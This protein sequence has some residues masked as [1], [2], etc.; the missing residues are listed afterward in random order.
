MSISSNASSP[1]N[2]ER[3]RKA[4][5]QDT[6]SAVKKKKPTEPMSNTEEIHT[7]NMAHQ[8]Q[9]K[10]AFEFGRGFGSG[11]AKTPENAEIGF[12][13][14]L[15]H[16]SQK[17]DSMG[18]TKATQNDTQELAD[19]VVRMPE[20]IQ[21]QSNETH[22]PA[23]PLG[24]IPAE[25]QL[26]PEERKNILLDMRSFFQKCIKKRKKDKTIILDLKEK[27]SHE[28]LKIRL[29]ILE[30]KQG[31]NVSRDEEKRKSLI[32]EAIELHEAENKF[33][34]FKSDKT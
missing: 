27:F 3:K 4:N 26:D 7:S 5:P 32:K 2:S 25:Q 11:L 23:Y 18:D 31:K 30:N 24:H 21:E 22:D 8:E 20:N 9:L 34:R 33:K 17:N 12:Q 28:E 29:C 13:L 15:K 14:F 1:Q 6:S 10:L 19:S 16:L